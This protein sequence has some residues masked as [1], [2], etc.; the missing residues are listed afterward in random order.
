V[1]SAKML[2]TEAH[3]FQLTRCSVKTCTEAWVQ[4]TCAVCSA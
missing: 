2:P 4:K 1:L 3:T